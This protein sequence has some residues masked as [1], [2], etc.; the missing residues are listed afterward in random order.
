MINRRMGR[1]TF[2][3][4]RS[5]VMHLLRGPSGRERLSDGIFARQ[6]LDHQQLDLAERYLRRALDADPNSAE[7]RSLMGVLHE[8]L[9]EY[10]AAFH[11]Y[12]IALTADRDNAVARAGI[13]RYCERFGFDPGNKAL[14]PACEGFGL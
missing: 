14:N 3:D 8:R 6:A 12:R 13:R 11:C 5:R 10:H 1:L 2:E 7:V 9:G 4:R